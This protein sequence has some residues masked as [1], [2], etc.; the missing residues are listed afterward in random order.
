MAVKPWKGAIFAPTNPPKIN[1]TPPDASLRLEWAHGYRSQVN[2]LPKTLGLQKQSLLWNKR[3][4]N[5]PCS[6]NRDIIRTYKKSSD[7]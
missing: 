4:N 1:S 3:K 6:R 7:I 5:L 2:T